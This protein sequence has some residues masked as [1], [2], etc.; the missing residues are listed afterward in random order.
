[1]SVT[2]SAFSGTPKAIGQAYG[3][4]FASQISANLDIL[5]R[6]RGSDPL[7]LEDKKF[8]SWIECQESLVAKNWPWIKE[9][10]EGVAQGASAEYNEILLLNLRA[11]QYEFYGP[12]ECCSSLAVTLSDGIVACA[13]ALDDPIE[14][15]CGPVKIVPENGNSFITFPITGTS[16]GNRGMNNRGLAIGIS[17]Q[18]LPGLKQLDDAINQDISL[19]VILQTCS[20][21]S[22]VREF[23]KAFPFTMNLVCADAK[24]EIFCA[25]NTSAG[26]LE[27]PAEAGYCALTNHVADDAF[28]YWLRSHGVNEFPESSTS[29]YRHGKLLEFARSRNGLCSHSEVMKLIGLRDD[30]DMGSI[31]NR[32][33]IYMTYANPPA[34]SQTFWVAESV[35]AGEY[36][37]FVPYS[38]G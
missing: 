5:V 19:R 30:D 27:M 4:Q 35:S 2:L 33:T 8:V 13:G 36:A 9:E 15:Y 22:D 12:G 18:I 1:M 24:G 34:D 6:R 37:Q 25:H 11:W 26:L 7:P 3:S 31:N 10:M 21:V 17:S 23:C 29:R 32:G 16:W 20:T 14:Y 28:M 38:L